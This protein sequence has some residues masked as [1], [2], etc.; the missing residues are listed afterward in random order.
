MMCQLAPDISGL[1]AAGFYFL[2][3]F[4]Q[5]TVTNYPIA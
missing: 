5:I 3:I 4:Q 2:L 1:C